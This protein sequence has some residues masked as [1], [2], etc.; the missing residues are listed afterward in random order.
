MNQ[1]DSLLWSAASNEV[2]RGHSSL[3]WF[4]STLNLRLATS[5]LT[6]LEYALTKT[7]RRKSFRMGSYEKRWGEGQLSL[8]KLR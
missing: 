3:R 1:F 2:A 7:R 6:P 5:A 4:P 8:T